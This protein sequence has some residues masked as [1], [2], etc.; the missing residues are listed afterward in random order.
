MSHNFRVIESA[1]E[2]GRNG[3]PRYFA[4]CLE[5]DSENGACYVSHTQNTARMA[6]VMGHVHQESARGIPNP[7]ANSPKYRGISW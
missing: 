2:F 5:G 6:F 1:N 7:L 4:V 3:E